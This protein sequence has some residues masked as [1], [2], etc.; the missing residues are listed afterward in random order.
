[1][2]WSDSQCVAGGISVTESL[3]MGGKKK[4]ERMGMD[5]SDAAI[6]TVTFWQH[7]SPL[8]MGPP[9][10]SQTSQEWLWGSAWSISA[11]TE[12]LD[13]KEGSSKAQKET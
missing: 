3:N 11:K 13:T 7:G 2:L 12:L 9:G 8:V 6:N 4:K 5:L 1:M 10:N